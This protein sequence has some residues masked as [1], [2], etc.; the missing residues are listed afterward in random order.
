MATPHQIQ[1]V[2]FR[3]DD[4]SVAQAE[5]HARWAVSALAF[6]DVKTA[7]KELRIALESLGAR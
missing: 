3:E 7:V 5:N 6:N 2:Q 1:P 4:E